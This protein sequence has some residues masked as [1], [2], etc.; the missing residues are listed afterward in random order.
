MWGMS[1]TSAPDPQGSQNPLDP[2][3]PE[4]LGAPPAN[5]FAD[6][7]TAGRGDRGQKRAMI[8][9]AAALV[10]LLFTGLMV[11]YVSAKLGS[12]AG[13]DRPAAAPLE[14]DDSRAE[15][16]DDGSSESGAVEW[17]A[18]M[19]TGGVLFSGDDEGDGIG[20][21]ASEAPEDNALPVPLDA[22]EIGAQHHIRVYLDYRCPF[23]ARFEDANAAT[24]ERAV[25][26]GGAV[27]ELH[28]LTFLDRV[29]QG[30]YYSS[31]S[32]GALACV[33]D[34]QPEVAWR[35]HSA[36][37]DPDFQPAENGP[38]HDNAAIL[39]ELDRATGGL[40]G[41]A[42]SCIEQ[43]RFV[44]F[45]QALN[46]WVFANPVPG[47]VDPELMVTGTPLVLVDG[48]PYPGDPGNSASFQ[49]FLEQQG[50]ELG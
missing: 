1:E 44:P 13:G 10:A 41:D 45:T 33:A 23:C 37:I 15:A 5:P 40:N 29:S 14:E 27:L 19:V 3:E 21:I 48:V 16:P 20:V 17:P 8:W 9:I 35:A 22:S 46:D 26:G 12:G 39:D 6:A 49:A 30:S 50:V 4:R 42:S 36:L 31:R 28:P 38:G 2:R 47:A 25:Q 7:E 43:E 34:A 18:N 11:W 24:L 32:A